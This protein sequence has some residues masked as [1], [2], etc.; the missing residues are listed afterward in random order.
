MNGNITFYYDKWGA[1]IISRDTFGKGDRLYS[2]ELEYIQ[3]IKHLISINK[4]IKLLENRDKNN[5][6]ENYPNFNE[7]DAVFK[8]VERKNEWDN[9]NEE[10]VVELDKKSKK[11]IVKKG[12]GYCEKY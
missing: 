8:E 12:G 2:C 10:I 1:F 11:I 7:I 6:K 4:Y 5:E 3:A 9:L